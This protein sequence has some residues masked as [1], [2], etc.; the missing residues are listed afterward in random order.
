MARSLIRAGAK[1]SWQSHVTSYLIN[2]LAN[3]PALEESQFAALWGTPWAEAKR[4]KYLQT[5]IF[6]GAFSFIKARF[7][8]S[9]ISERHLVL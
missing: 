4:T 1:N 9:Y 6:V 3:I 2:S 5:R 8:L 7:Q